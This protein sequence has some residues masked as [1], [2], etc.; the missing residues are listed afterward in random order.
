MIK[1]LQAAVE[2]EAG[3]LRAARATLTNPTAKE[4]TYTVE[5]YLGADKRATSGTLTVTVPAGSSVEV[6]FPVVVPAEEAVFPVFLDIW[7]E[8]KI[9]RH[10]R[11]TQDVRVKVTVQVELGP[12]I[13]D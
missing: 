1:A 12:I 4:L 11:S 5:L 13:W 7:H 9:L 8:G 2:L 6:S 10:F 3:T